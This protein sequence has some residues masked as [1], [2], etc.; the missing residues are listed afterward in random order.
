MSGFWVFLGYF[1]LFKGSLGGLPFFIRTHMCVGLSA[2][3]TC[4][5]GSQGDV[6]HQVRHIPHLSLLLRVR[7]LE[8][9]RQ[10]ARFVEG[11]VGSRI[12]STCPFGVA[13]Y[14][15]LSA[16]LTCLSSTYLRLKQ[17]RKKTSAET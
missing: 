7:P 13:C 4:C 17:Q 8:S 15:Q 2:K 5:F 1:P 10:A 14:G 11:T 3:A 6:L 9:L 12:E 16:A